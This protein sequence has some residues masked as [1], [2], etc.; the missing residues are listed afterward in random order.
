MCVEARLGEE[1]TLTEP[2]TGKRLAAV[3]AACGLPD[4]LDDEHTA[5]SLLEAAG[6]DKKARAGSLR[7]VML[8]RIGQVAPSPDG[9]THL[10]PEAGCLAPLASALRKASEASDSAA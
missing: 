6:H 2:G 5:E 4:V 10:I 8:E 3:L 7:C 1:L 9:W